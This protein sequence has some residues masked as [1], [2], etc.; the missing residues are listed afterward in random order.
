LRPT[1]NNASDFIGTYFRRDVVGFQPKLIGFNPG[2]FPL[3]VLMPAVQA[4]LATSDALDFY[5]YRELQGVQPRQDSVDPGHHRFV[6]NV[7]PGNRVY[8]SMAKVAEV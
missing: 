7:P 8:R 2:T 4:E 6:A 3:P 1:D 5:E